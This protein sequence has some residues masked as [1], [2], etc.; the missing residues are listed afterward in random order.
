MNE[1][2]RRYQDPSGCGLISPHNSLEVSQELE[3]LSEHYATS[4]RKELFNS[5]WSYSS[6]FKISNNKNNSNI[7]F[8][9]LKVPLTDSK[10]EDIIQSDHCKNLCFI[11][12]NNEGEYKTS[13]LY[14]SLNDLES[15]SA[16]I[17][18]ESIRWYNTNK[19]LQHFNE[20][21]PC[22]TLL[23]KRELTDSLWF[24]LNI[25]SNFLLYD[26]NRLL[27]QI[28]LKLSGHL[29]L[30]KYNI[31]R[32]LNDHNLCKS[33]TGIP[34]NVDINFKEF[35]N[36][37][38]LR[39]FNKYYFNRSQ[40]GMELFKIIMYIESNLLEFNVLTNSKWFNTRKSQSENRLTVDTTSEQDEGN[41][42]LDDEELSSLV[43]LPFNS[44]LKYPFYLIH[45][46]CKNKFEDSSGIDN[47]SKTRLSAYSAT[48][49]GDSLDQ[50]TNR[51]TS[52]VVMN[53]FQELHSI[54]MADPHSNQ[55]DC[56][57][58]KTLN[59]HS[60]NII[61]CCC[62]SY[63]SQ[64]Y[65][66]WLKSY[67][68]PQHITKESISTEIC[69]TKYLHCLSF[70]K[71]DRASVDRNLFKSGDNNNNSNNN[72]NN[73]ED[74]KTNR[75]KT[76]PDII[77][78]NGMQSK[79]DK[80]FQHNYMQK[81][82]TGRML[83]QPKPD[84]HHLCQWNTCMHTQYA[85]KTTEAV[86]HSFKNPIQ[87][88][89]PHQLLFF[90]DEAVKRTTSEFAKKKTYA[91]DNM[92]NVDHQL[93]DP[94][95]PDEKFSP[96][97]LGGEENKAMHIG[98]VSKTD[99]AVI[100]VKSKEKIST[101]EDKKRMTA[102]S[103][104]LDKTKPD[105]VRL[106]SETDALQ[107][108][109]G[110]KLR[111]REFDQAELHESHYTDTQLR[112]AS[113]FGVQIRI[114]EETGESGGRQKAKHS[115]RAPKK[116]YGTSKDDD[117]DGDD[118]DDD[119][120][121]HD[122]K[123]ATRTRKSAN[124]Q[125][126]H[127]EGLGYVISPDKPDRMLFRD[128][129]DTISPEFYDLNQV[130][131]S[132]M[133]HTHS[134]MTLTW[135][136]EDMSKHSI[137][138]LNEFNKA[139]KYPETSSP[140]EAIHVKVT[141]H[142]QTSS[143]EYLT[144]VTSEGLSDYWEKSA[145]HLTQPHDHLSHEAN[146]KYKSASG[147]EDEP[148]G[149]HDISGKK[150]TASDRY[151]EKSPQPKKTL[152]S[153]NLSENSLQGTIGRAEKTSLATA[154]AYE[155]SKAHEA[156]KDLPYETK[157][158]KTA[159]GSL[160]DLENSFS[161][162]LKLT[163]GFDKSH[164]VLQSDDIQGYSKY[165]DYQAAEQISR[166]YSITDRKDAGRLSL[167]KNYSVEES[168]KLH[169]SDQLKKVSMLDS[170]FDDRR[171]IMTE[172][173]EYD[174][175][176][177]TG[178]RQFETIEPLNNTVG[179]FEFLPTNAYELTPNVI[180]SLAFDISMIEGIHQST[181]LQIIKDMKK[182]D[183]KDFNKIDTTK[184][185]ELQQ[186][187]YSSS[188]MKQNEDMPSRLLLLSDEHAEECFSDTDLLD[189]RRKQ[190]KS[191]KPKRHTLQHPG[192][193][194]KRPERRLI[195]PHKIP[196]HLDVQTRAHLRRKIKHCRKKIIAKHLN[197][198]KRQQKLLPNRFDCQYFAL[199]N[200]KNKELVKEIEE[201]Q[202]EVDDSSQKLRENYITSPYN[203]DYTS[204]EVSKSDGLTP[205]RLA[206][207][208]CFILPNSINQSV[209]P[210]WYDVISRHQMMEPYQ[211]I[212]PFIKFTGGQYCQPLRSEQIHANFL[213]NSTNL[214]EFFPFTKPKSLTQLNNKDEKS[215]SLSE[216]KSLS[217]GSIRR[218]R[219]CSSTSS[220]RRM[221]I[222][223]N[224]HHQIDH[225]QYGVRSLNNCALL[226]SKDYLRSLLSFK[227]ATQR[228]LNNPRRHTITTTSAT[229]HLHVLRPNVEFNSLENLY[230][231]KAKIY[232]L[233]DYEESVQPCSVD[234]V[235]FTEE[236]QQINPVLEKC[237]K[238][239]RSEESSQLKLLTFRVISK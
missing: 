143:P 132:A 118:D 32:Q 137:H 209:N 199:N 98:T 94:L 194:R 149:T 229:K 233:I 70:G 58:R 145:D 2:K 135:V 53:D 182:Y 219:R 204:K 49:V 99:D 159:V 41:T 61:R 71:R 193:H 9:C 23:N 221:L 80:I 227:K 59:C 117:E 46:N 65:Y 224:H 11:M 24:K 205:E 189:N 162:F 79:F 44:L 74:D 174:R 124:T 50:N 171:E 153:D 238:L 66:T 216:D 226:S 188:H 192:V 196:L 187:A 82:C 57:Q 163:E 129:S 167:D 197:L 6:K 136:G 85:V 103:I 51:R 203:P 147:V 54:L 146:A 142:K 217:S 133:P 214:Q 92:L 56:K 130:K 201:I 220:D 17:E 213:R 62:F 78:R 30:R 89:D 223:T 75:S 237:V 125:K 109:D 14:A 97:D 206:S 128:N 120:D 64:I 1:D 67:S 90:E 158:E 13:G 127:D 155:K 102:D 52:I 101:K 76:L 27:D 165:L 231:L 68:T 42:K 110:K 105:K 157:H 3:H 25:D 234:A 12:S 150:A 183:A 139:S 232:S 113:G 140:V 26:L 111:S 186:D 37:A 166:T 87:M 177:L 40:D 212:N 22:N 114:G 195:Y 84:M 20:L 69:L 175:K 34:N 7:L 178:R 141:S 151:D 95:Q 96:K 115:K 107:K 222:N 185:Y 235:T 208:G 122:K 156:F 19:T 48:H 176:Q 210:L 33:F 63:C 190:A 83:A 86:M 218:R 38:F 144:Q 72:N 35:E 47:C 91:E 108:K 119:G 173:L 198:Y 123:R 55:I 138:I 181:A 81:S 39:H 207:L 184:F 104:L 169:T 31:H 126:Q 77:Y 100:E 180:D 45:I 179:I 29:Y 106:A 172:H 191:T 28:L 161:E 211:S 16:K 225:G 170:L 88:K 116:A 10:M 228:K 148:K 73:N 230:T 121:D 131:T 15:W 8:S 168:S 4:S 164:T 152:A 18:K 5:F 60:V 215:L 154:A 160:N 236:R 21:F 134:E 112:A 239:M 43:E 200:E 93:R 36:I 202:K